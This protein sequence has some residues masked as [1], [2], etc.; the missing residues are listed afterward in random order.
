[1]AA[2]CPLVAHLAC[3]WPPGPGGRGARPISGGGNEGMLRGRHGTRAPAAS[4]QP[5][6]ARALARHQSG[7]T[8]PPRFVNAHPVQCCCCRPIPCAGLSASA[9]LSVRLVAAQPV[10][11]SARHPVTRR[12]PSVPFNRAAP[13]PLRVPVFRPAGRSTAPAG[14]LPLQC[15][16]PRG[17]YGKRADSIEECLA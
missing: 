14:L 7:C 17:G 16:K 9:C 11:H 1:M 8:G 2:A 5:A 3:H 10:H 13:S 6:P 12:G 15:T 4:L